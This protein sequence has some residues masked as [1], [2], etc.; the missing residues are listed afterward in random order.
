MAEKQPHLNGAYY[1]PAIPP[2][3][4]YHHHGRRSGC[5]G[6]CLFN[7]LFKLIITVIVIIGIAILVLWLVFRPNKLKFH[8][9]DATLTQFNFTTNNKLQYNLALN[10]TVRNP[11]KRIGIYYDRIDA[12]AFYEDNRFGY[13][14]LTPFYQGHK[15]TSFLEPVF[16]GSQL[17]L[18]DSEELTQYKQENASS[19]YSIDVKLYMRI[20]FKLGRLKTRKFKPEIECDLKVPLKSSGRIFQTTKCDVDF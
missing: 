16:Q 14:P 19:V 15:N 18:L 8:V 10:I 13:A 4:N 2:P 7:F 20:R 3:N 12:T 17:L 1:G 6:C 9:T 5:C 11:N